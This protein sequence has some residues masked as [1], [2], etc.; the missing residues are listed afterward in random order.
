MSGIGIGGSEVE[1]LGVST[2]FIADFRG[3]RLAAVVV[4]FPVIFVVVAMSMREV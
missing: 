4:F 1:L 2:A 3:L